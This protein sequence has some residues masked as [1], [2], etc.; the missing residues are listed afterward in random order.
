MMSPN[1]LAAISDPQTSMRLVFVSPA[2]AWKLPGFG[3]SEAAKTDRRDQNPD[4]AFWLHHESLAVGSLPAGHN[5]AFSAGR[6][7]NAADEIS[8]GT[9]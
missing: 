9:G 2:P 7:A 1:T 3:A 6:L 5:I 8:H 4:R